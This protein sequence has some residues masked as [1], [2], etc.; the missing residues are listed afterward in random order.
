L[1]VN[2]IHHNDHLT[3]THLRGPAFVD[4]FL[5]TS[6]YIARKGSKY[7]QECA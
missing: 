7:P 4:V 2:N 3:Q 6:C 5:F 1:Q